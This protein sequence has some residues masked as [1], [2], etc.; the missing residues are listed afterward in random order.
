MQDR[1]DDTEAILARRR[2]LVQSTLAGLGVG[3]VAVTGC[4]PKPC[5]T[6]VPDAC[7][8]PPPPDPEV[9]LKPAPPDPKPCLKPK[10]PEPKP[11]LS[12]SVDPRPR[13][14]KP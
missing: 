12:E 8:K 2:F 11:C 1:N 6:L 13:S 3:V 14:T 4:A 10:P 5:L 9:C 7:L